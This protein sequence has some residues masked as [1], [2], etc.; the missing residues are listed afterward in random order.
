MGCTESLP[1]KD[2]FQQPHEMDRVVVH[3]DA[4]PS[5][6]KPT[7]VVVR[8][9]LF[10]WS[11]RSFGIL[12]G[13]G[14]PFHDLQVKGKAIAFRDQMA[15]LDGNGRLVAVLLR[16]FELMGQ[17]FKI[18]L[19]H[20]ARKGQQPS[21]RTYEGQALYT[22]AKTERVPLST[23]QYVFLDGDE[24]PTYTVHRSGNWWPKT[25]AVRKH[26]R[27]A[28]LMEGG[29]WGWSSRF[30]GYQITCAPGIDACLMVCICAA[31]DEM[32]ELERRNANNNNNYNSW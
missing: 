5:S 14:A 18:Y 17:T 21:D 19:P 9:K 27:P 11:D 15:L 25:R 4:A 23:T 6:T 32:D 8:K 20:P 24:S 10:S 28:A 3:Y 26:G 16:K 22:Y 30:D 13:D 12:T 29:T 1:D 2:A 31:C 7:V